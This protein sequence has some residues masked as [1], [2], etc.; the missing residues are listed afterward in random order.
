M[1]GD[2]EY[3]YD[4]RTDLNL[5]SIFFSHLLLVSCDFDVRPFCADVGC[6]W[7]CDVP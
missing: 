7:W 6:G 1:D 5:T 2:D 4:E 3:D